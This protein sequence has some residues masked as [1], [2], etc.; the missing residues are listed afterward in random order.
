M[1]TK[2]N[3]F[4]GF[5]TPFLTLS[6]PL[7]SHSKIIVVYDFRLKPLVKV[8]NSGLTASRIGTLA[9][10]SG[11][12]VTRIQQTSFGIIGRSRAAVE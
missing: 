5:I 3:F 8:F 7:T 10:N 4:W 1:S 12:T 2:W 6:A 9:A 11:N